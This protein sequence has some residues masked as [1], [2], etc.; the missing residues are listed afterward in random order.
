M[1]GRTAAVVAFGAFAL[2]AAITAAEAA[3][4]EC[5]QHFAGGQAPDLVREALA[6]KA[7]PIC[8]A[9]YALLHSGVSR[10]PLWTAE[11]L[12]AESITAARALKRKNTFHPDP[13]LP[14]EER[15]ELEDYKG[16]GFDRGHMAPSGDMPNPQAQDESFSLAN[17]IPQHPRMN[18]IIWEWIESGV[19]DYAVRHGE[20][21]V[22]TGPIYQRGGT[23]QRV[24]GRVI[25]PTHAFKAIYDP[26]TGTAGAYVVENIDT[27]RHQ[28]LSIAELE[29]LTGIAVF[30]ELPAAVKATAMA[31]PTPKPR[32]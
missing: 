5:P 1:F 6:T 29:Q 19:R 27:K 11:H 3:P 12:T 7:R 21:Y 32:T 4:T 15:A 22:V 23:F 13:N 31:L 25:V 10:T 8:Y 14:A 20:V 2:A 26:K 28:V 9:A 24:N 18:Q 17:I 16:S 30:P